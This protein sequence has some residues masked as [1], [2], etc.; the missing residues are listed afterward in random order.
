MPRRYFDYLPE[1]EPLNRVSSIGAYMIAT[2]FVIAL[3]AVVKALVEKQP[4]VG[5]NPWGAKTLEWTTASPPPHENFLVTPKVTTGPYD[6][7]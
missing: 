1:F 7:R 5:D 4:P 6:Y 3:I 2:G